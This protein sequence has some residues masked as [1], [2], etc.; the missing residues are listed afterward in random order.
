MSLTHFFKHLTLTSHSSSKTLTQK[1]TINS[2][3]DIANMFSE[4]LTY[5]AASS[6]TMDEDDYG[7]TSNE[8]CTESM[9]PEF[10]NV[11]VCYSQSA[12]SVGLK[13]I[14]SYEVKTGELCEWIKKTQE[15]FD[16]VEVTEALLVVHEWKTPPQVSVEMKVKWSIYRSCKAGLLGTRHTGSGLPM[17]HFSCTCKMFNKTVD[18]VSTAEIAFE[19]STGNESKVSY[20]HKAVQSAL[21]EVDVSSESETEVSYSDYCSSIVPESISNSETYNESF[22]TFD[23]WCVQ[24]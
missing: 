20:S 16:P 22:G 11:Y 15:S 21:T 5:F 24:D 23:G 10:E 18:G 2:H 1:P 12:D 4:A 19:R 6:T 13:E 3:K 17:S 9:F 14:S 8:I 7:D